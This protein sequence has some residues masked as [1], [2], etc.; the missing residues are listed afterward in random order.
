M[1]DLATDHRKAI[2][3][4]NCFKKSKELIELTHHIYGG[5]HIKVPFMVCPECIDE[6]IQ[7]RCRCRNVADMTGELPGVEAA[8]KSKRINQLN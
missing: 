4:E 8:R 7:Y 2:Y 5:L 1:Y 6:V 3:C